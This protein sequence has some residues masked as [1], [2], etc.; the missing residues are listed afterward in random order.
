[1][2]EARIDAKGVVRDARVISGPDELRAAA[3][4]SVPGWQYSTK[5]A[6]HPIVEIA[7]E[8]NLPKYR[9]VSA[10]PESVAGTVKSIDFQGVSSEMKDKVLAQI[11]LKEGDSIS[12]EARLQIVH[13]VGS[14]DQ[15]LRVG[16]RKIENG[17]RIIVTMPPPSAQGL[18]GGTISSVGSAAPAAPE[19]PR[20][21]RSD[22]G[23]ASHLLRIVTAPYPPPA[24][25]AKI[26]GVV[27][28]MVTIAKDGTVKHIELKSG[29]PLLVESAMNAVKQ[30]IYRPALLNGE[31]VEIQ[32]S[33]DVSYS[34]AGTTPQVWIRR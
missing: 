25:R 24:K 16:F 4:K 13:A 2:L 30:W 15:H 34:L 27:R 21:L 10:P 19:A 12:E 14:V 6:A 32:T 8:F 22:T 26:Q 23:H 33:V 1:M 9:I 11:A 20:R 28:M 3:L 18:L 5:R 29:H 31:A 17:T 7:I